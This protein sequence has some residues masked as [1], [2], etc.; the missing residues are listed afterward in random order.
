[1]LSNRLKPKRKDSQTARDDLR[2]I[3]P[4]MVQLEQMMLGGDNDYC[5]DYTYIEM[6]EKNL[7]Y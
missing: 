5:T 6:A 7:T 3:G 2:N 4:R 1:M